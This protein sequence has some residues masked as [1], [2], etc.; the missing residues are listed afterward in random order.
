MGFWVALFPC[1]ELLNPVIAYL[2]QH[3]C[4]LRTKLRPFL[5]FMLVA[6]DGS[7]LKLV[8]DS[9]N[10][11]R[12]LNGLL[13]LKLLLSAAQQQ[14]SASKLL[15]N[16]LEASNTMPLLMSSTF[17]ALSGSAAKP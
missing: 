2:F 7:P 4:L 12:F 17:K 16:R 5:M 11:V 9:L 1:Q 3:Y 15:S 10:F 14:G 13:K 6:S 8:I